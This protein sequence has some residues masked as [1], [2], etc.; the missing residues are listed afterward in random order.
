MHDAKLP[1]LDGMSGNQRL[2]QLYKK[3]ACG[4]EEAPYN[5]INYRHVPNSM[6]RIQA[7]KWSVNWTGG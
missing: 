7:G 3:C 6:V 2:V 4:L 1:G 5:I